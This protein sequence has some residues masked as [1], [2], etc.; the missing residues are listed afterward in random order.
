VTLSKNGAAFASPA[1]AVSEVGSGWYQVAGH[2][3]DSNPLGPL[4][5][6]ATAG[7]AD[8][9]DAFFE[10]IAFDPTDAAGLGLS[11][12]DTTVGSRSSHSAADVWAVGSRTLTSFGTLVADVA[13]AVWGAATRTLSAFGFNVTVGSNQDKTGYSLAT[14]PPTA[15]AITDAV[16]DELLS[17]H[18]Q[19][20]SVA[21]GISLAGGG[22][23]PLSNAYPGLYADGTYGAYLRDKL[24][25]IHVGQVVVSNPINP[26]TGSITLIRGDADN[27]AT[28]RLLWTLTGYPG[29]SGATVQLSIN[30]GTPLTGSV[31]STATD[32]GDQVVA[33][34]LTV[35]QTAALAG[36]VLPGAATVVL[37]TNNPMTFW[38]G[39]IDAR[40]RAAT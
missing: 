16:L 2:A 20:G 29:L 31:L 6:H 23:D 1:G 34:D 30:G 25:L 32:G 19:P 3:T 38:E 26:T 9:T 14:T 13:A 24:G 33:V 8:T 28:R 37:P 17:G 22:T 10:V 27:A 40:G 36:Q 4:L 11:R 12:L 5:L 39:Y 18:T 35:A 15:A 7:G 21:A